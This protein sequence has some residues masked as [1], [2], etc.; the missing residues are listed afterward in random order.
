VR[1]WP[2]NR[3]VAG[4]HKRECDRCGFDFL[5]SEMLREWN[6]KIVCSDCFEEKDPQ[7][8]VKVHKERNVIID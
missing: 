6:G 3:F 4:T 2:R 7:L 8:E 5:R 1:V